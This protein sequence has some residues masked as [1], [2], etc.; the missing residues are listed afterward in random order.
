MFLGLWAWAGRGA[1][2]ALALMTLKPHLLLVILPYTLWQWR[3]EGR[4]LLIL[5][6]AVAALWLLPMAAHP[7]WPL[8]WLENVVSLA[9]QRDITPSVFFVTNL[10]EWALVPAAVAAAAIVVWSW[11]RGRVFANLAGLAVNPAVQS[12][13]LAL[14]AGP[15]VLWRTVIAG[16][17]GWL[18]FLITGQ[19]AAHFVILPVAFWE[20]SRISVIRETQASDG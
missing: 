16:W 14:I 3:R 13:N 19:F 8:D 2:L 5:L 6:A 17:I 7:R 1:P 20:Q 9:G 11:P 15:W 10:G 4:R 18:A 12:Y